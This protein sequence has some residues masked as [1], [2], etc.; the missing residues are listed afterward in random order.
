MNPTTYSL[1]RARQDDMLRQAAQRRLVA[2]ARSQQPASAGQE[3]GPRRERTVAGWFR[4]R[5]R[6]L[7][8]TY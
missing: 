2:E 8:E 4:L 5:P 6:P 1:G 3:T 7:A